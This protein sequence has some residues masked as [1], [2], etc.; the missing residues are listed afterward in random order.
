MNY[1]LVKC[2][3]FFTP[4]M[5]ASADM[6]M[7]S[8]DRMSVEGQESFFDS[9]HPSV[10][11]LARAQQLPGGLQVVLGFSLPAFAHLPGLFSVFHLHLPRPSP[12]FR[13]RFRP[14]PD[15]SPSSFKPH[16]VPCFTSL[17]TLTSFTGPCITKVWVF[18]CLHPSSLLFLGEKKS[19]LPLYPP[20]L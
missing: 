11:A 16:Q 17:Q 19:I 7:T 18:S 6:F 8:G 9:G 10:C 2:C 20:C 12:S 15:V 4:N 13:A 3:L 1:R 5:T 14:K